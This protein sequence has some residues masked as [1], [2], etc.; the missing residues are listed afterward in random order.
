MFT[1]NILEKKVRTIKSFPCDRLNSHFTTFYVPF[2]LGFSFQKEKNKSPKYFAI[3][4]DEVVPHPGLCDLS[5]VQVPGNH[6]MC[7]FCGN[8]LRSI[9]LTQ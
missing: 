1:I 3:F 6:S 5:P 7:V 4:D 2:E 9:F 8:Y